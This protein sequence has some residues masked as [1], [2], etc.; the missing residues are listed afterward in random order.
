MLKV[1]IGIM[2]F[3]LSYIVLT[4]IPQPANTT[5]G[6][7]YKSLDLYENVGK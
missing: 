1:L 7:Y 5:V 4:L 3:L 2:M 6:T